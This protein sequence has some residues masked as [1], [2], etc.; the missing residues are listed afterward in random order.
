VAAGVRR[1][2]WGLVA[3]NT[4]FLIMYLVLNWIQQVDPVLPNWRPDYYLMIS[5]VSLFT[6][7][8]VSWAMFFIRDDKKIPVM[9]AFLKLG[10]VVH[11]LSIVLQ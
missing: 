4:G 2:R 9:D 6:G 8:W 5:G 1:A 10:I 3:M 11:L 7:F